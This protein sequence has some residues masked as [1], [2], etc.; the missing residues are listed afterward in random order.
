MSKSESLEKN[1]RGLVMSSLD[2]NGKDYFTR[3]K[4]TFGDAHRCA[5]QLCKRTYGD[6]GYIKVIVRD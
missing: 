5:E 2:I 1:F 4:T 3:W 6:N